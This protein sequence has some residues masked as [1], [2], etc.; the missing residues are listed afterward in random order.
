MTTQV[1]IKHDGPDHKDILVE[2]FDPNTGKIGG[3]GRVKAGT[4]VRWAVYD[5]CAIR[6]VEIDTVTS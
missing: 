2:L 3:G 1:I 6:I 4:E 5:T